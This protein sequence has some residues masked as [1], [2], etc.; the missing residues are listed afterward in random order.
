M[1]ED[2]HA[3]CGSLTRKVAV[4]SAGLEEVQRSLTDIQRK[5]R[6]EVQR[7]AEM[8]RTIEATAIHARR[9]ADEATVRR[10]RAE[11][12]G[13][14]AVAEEIRIDMTR[15]R[16][17]T[18]KASEVAARGEAS[19]VHHAAR[20]GALEERLGG[21]QRHTDQLSARV[22]TCVKDIEKCS[23]TGAEAAFQLRALDERLHGLPS[24][25]QGVMEHQPIFDTG[26]ARGNVTSL[27][28]G[29]IRELHNHRLTADQTFSDPPL[30]CPMLSPELEEVND[31]GHDGVDVHAV[32]NSELQV[33]PETVLEAQVRWLGDESPVRCCVNVTSE[34][35]PVTISRR[36]SPNSD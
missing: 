22:N 16:S 13:A 23:A 3:T 21:L 12:S 32:P 25:R 29:A 34:A 9:V 17:L 28:D 4:S 2:E 10:A 14:S 24:P 33:R 18:T 15:A 31:G 19:A 36:S 30:G 20:L 7:Q 6:E 35:S 27:V 26:D 1:G 8:C 5:A 11:A